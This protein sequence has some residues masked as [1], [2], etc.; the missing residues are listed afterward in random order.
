VPQARCTYTTL[1]SQANGM[2]GYHHGINEMHV[3]IGCTHVRTRLGG[4]AKGLRANDLVRLALERS[5]TAR[6]AVD[7]ITDLLARHGQ[8]SSNGGS[9][10]D[11]AFLIADGGEAFAV[12][13]CG[14]YWVLQEISEVRA[15]SDCCSVRQ[16][17]NRIAPGLADQAIAR[18]WWPED[19]SKLDFAG[20]LALA[21]A[22]ISSAMRRWGRA[23]YLL[24]E[25][26]GNI[27]GAFLR[28]LLADHYEETTEGAA[29]NTVAPLPLCQHGKRAT[30]T[31][32]AV[33]LVAELDPK[34]ESP[35]LAWYAFGPPCL[36]VYFP[37]FLAGQLPEP[38][39]D[40]ALD[41]LARGLWTG[42]DMTTAREQVVRLQEELDQQTAEFLREALELK[43]QEQLPEL[44]RQATLFHQHALE[45]FEKM[46]EELV[47]EQHAAPDTVVAW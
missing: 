15:M 39:S 24:Q 3:A 47:G 29:A 28:R 44:Q 40:G 35:A 43:R 45:S 38:F 25:Q 10:I 12:E 46:M 41:L 31:R 17:W 1:G 20:T 32:T 19:G 8:A 4:G 11:G 22:N 16:D 6:Q 27:D 33:S 26:N 23:T 9:G 21:G 13:S 30:E 7:S 34:V 18:A 5:A 2:W 42:A 36:T 14:Q 37:I